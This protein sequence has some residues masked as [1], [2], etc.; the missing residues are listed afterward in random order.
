MMEMD[1]I[2]HFVAGI[3]ICITIAF[4]MMYTTQNATPLASAAC[5]LI[6]ACLAGLGKE[7]FDWFRNTM[8]DVRDLLATALGGLLGAVCSLLL[9]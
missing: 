9:M 5:G 3:V 6:A 8:F 1:K 7:A 2:L 4:V